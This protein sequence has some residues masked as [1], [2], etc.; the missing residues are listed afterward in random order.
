MCVCVCVKMVAGVMDEVIRESDWVTILV[1][2][3]AV[4]EKGK[5]GGTCFGR[6]FW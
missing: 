2:A 3:K 6:V 1:K 5:G 4:A